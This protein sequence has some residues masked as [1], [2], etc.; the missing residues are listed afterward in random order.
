MAREQ[1]TIRLP[2]ELMEQLWQKA[3]EW[4]KSRNGLMLNILWQYVRTQE[5]G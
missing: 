4:G 3:Q 2:S 5:V 1:T